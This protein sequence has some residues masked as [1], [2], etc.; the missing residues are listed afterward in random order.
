MK[1]IGRILLPAC[2]AICV[3]TTVC[4]PAFAATQWTTTAT[5]GIS[6]SQLASAGDLG[7]L[8]V[9]TPLTV[10]V[11]LQVQSKNAL[12]SYVKALSN[13]KSPLYGQFLTPQQFASKYAPTQAQVQQVVNYL[14]Q[15]GF[16][17]IVVEPNNLLISADGTAQQAETAFNT[18]LEQF[19]QFGQNVFGNTK[20]AQ[21]PEALGSIVSGVLGLNTIGKMKPTITLPSAPQYGVS[22]TPTQFQQ[23]YNANT[24]KAACCTAIAIMAEGDLTGVVSDLRIAEKAFGLPQVP[25]TIVQVGLASPDVSGADEWDLDS[26]YSSGM[27]GTLKQLYLYATTS[28]SDSDLALEFSR[29]ATDNKARAASASLGECEVFPYLDGSMV[30]DDMIFLEAAAQG[31]TFFASAGDTGSFCPASVAG[32]N[33]VPAGA[34]F[35][36]YPA[37]SPYVVGVGG[38]TLL[39][40]ADGNYDQEIAWYAGGGGIS[41]FEN[42]PY[43]QT[44]AVPLISAT[45][46][47]GVPDIAMDADPETG[48]LVYVNGVAEGVGGT[49]LSSPLALGSWARII[50]TD[51]KVGFASPALYSL[52]DGT[53]VIGSYPNGGF[54]DITIGANGLYAA[55]PGY[56]LTTGLG[57]L[58]VNQLTPDLAK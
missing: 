13:P 38:T 40:N 4:Q 53:G 39:I 30:I 31:Q 14:K 25:V 46:T 18:R 35:V 45:A 20:P 15:S 29:W 56:D 12:L 58:V 3:A 54:R 55:A 42:A 24:V 6:L 7:P 17:N 27:A 2:A 44:A 43:W 34:P 52:Y 5:Q 1:K 57:T 47:R 21:V 51:W 49:S 36:N 33:G 16:S 41:Q 19:S 9:S 8:S 26:Q 10:R 22:Y 50:N 37:A 11:G 32:V 23:F 48:A 28:L